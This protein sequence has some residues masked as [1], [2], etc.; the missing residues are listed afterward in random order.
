MQTYSGEALEHMLERFQT[1]GLGA[2]F[3]FDTLME[4]LHQ[5]PA[6]EVCLL[7]GLAHTGK[8][9]M[10]AQAVREL[11]DYENTCWIQCGPY[12]QD[13]V[14]DI[15]YFLYQHPSYRYIFI[16]DASNLEYVLDTAVI[17]YDQFVKEDGCH[18][19]LCGDNSLLFHKM[20][21]S[22]PVWDDKAGVWEDWTNH[23]KRVQTTYVPFFEYSRLMGTDDKKH[24]IEYG[25]FLDDRLQA[26][27]DT[28]ED[29]IEQEIGRNI[30]RTYETQRNG[31]NWGPLLVPYADECLYEYIHYIIECAVR[32][33]LRRLFLVWQGSDPL[34][35]RFHVYLVEF[36][37]ALHRLHGQR[38]ERCSQATAKEVRYVLQ[39]MDIIRWQGTNDSPVFRVPSLCYHFI[40]RF[41]R[42]VE[43]PQGADEGEWRRF[44]ASVD[45]MVCKEMVRN[46]ELQ[47]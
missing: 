24:Y 41:F 2:R 17:F 15:R 46:I 16:E 12:E 7:Y 42:E 30:E 3:A 22:D 11:Q 6:S 47:S 25:G 13:D 31:R 10:M 38:F 32:T 36:E 1:Q 21:W 33:Y 8:K 45:E 19:V 27:S 39:E 43:A 20:G 5:E 44:M 35:Q 9:T 4:Y 29:F 34:W 18:I 40:R 23:V 28:Y 26:G 14:G 37:E